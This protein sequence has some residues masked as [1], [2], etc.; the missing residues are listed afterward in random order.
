MKKKDQILLEEA[1]Q[2]INENIL[3]KLNPFKKQQPQQPQQPAA[4]PIDFINKQTNEK[5]SFYL[6]DL[7]K[8]KDSGEVYSGKGEST[9]T[10]FV[11]QNE[12]GFYSLKEEHYTQYPSFA[13]FYTIIGGPFKTE[14]EATNTVSAVYAEDG[15]SFTPTNA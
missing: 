14:Q 10:Y 12:S 13:D 5:V 11:G 7:K 2:K 15:K 4:K 8:I 9:F 3:S 6:K 1:Y